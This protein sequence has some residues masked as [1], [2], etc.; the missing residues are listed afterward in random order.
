ML[1]FE[2]IDSDD[3]KLIDEKEAK[4][5][6][7]SMSYFHTTATIR[8]NSIKFRE[9][10]NQMDVNRDGKISPKEF[11]NSL[12]NSVPDTKMLKLMVDVEALDKRIGDFESIN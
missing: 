3:N 11:D 1:K 4:K 9:E 12:K 10:W 8:Q 7:R 6:L 2:A 5:H